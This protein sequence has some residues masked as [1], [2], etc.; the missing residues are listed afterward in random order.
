M[1]PNDFLNGF[2]QDLR[3]AGRQLWKDP[4]SAALIILTLSLGIGANTTVF[5]VVQ[6]VL[7]SPLP[8]DGADRLALIRVDL[9]AAP[10]TPALAPG[11]IT[12]FEEQSRLL[13]GVGFLYGFSVYFSA[14]GQTERL[15]AAVASDDIFRLFRIRP[16]LGRTLGP[17]DKDYGSGTYH[18][19][20]ISHE[21]WQRR[22]GGDPEVIG[23]SVEVEAR[24]R[25]IVGVMPADLRML[26][27]EG[28]GIP[29]KVAVWRPDLNDP[30]K[31]GHH[32]LKPIA[33]LRPGVSF[34]QAQ[35]EIDSIA[36]RFKAR[37]SS[38]YQDG[39][40][41]F[42]ILPLRDDLVAPVRPTLMALLAAAGLLLLICCSNTANLLLARMTGRRQEFSIRAA[43]GASRLRIFRQVLGES[44][45]PAALGGA[46]G[47][48]LAVWAVAALIRL[49]PL[50]LPRLD[51]IR[52]NAQVFGFC[53]AISLLSGT[54]ASLFPAWSL[55]RRNQIQALGRGSRH[56][57]H[58][59]R[60]WVRSSLMASQVALTFL[61]LLASGLLLRSFINL[62]SVEMGFSTEGV[63]TFELS[64]DETEPRERRWLRARSAL[65]RL[66]STAGIEVVGA[67]STGA[68]NQ[69]G[70]P[71]GG[72]G[73]S[74]SS[75][76][77]QK[78]SA[79]SQGNPMADYQVV[80]PGYFE[81]LG[82]RVHSGRA[83]TDQ[84]VEGKRKLAV[85]NQ[86]LAQSFWPA[87]NAVGK[88]L[89][90]DPPS[91]QKS[92]DWYEVVG[93][94]DPVRI[95]GPRQQEGPQIYLPYWT[96]PWQYLSFVVRTDL[97]EQ[98]LAPLL[99]RELGR[100]DGLGPPYNFSSMKVYRE[101]SFA[102]IRL[103]SY[104]F[105][106]LAGMGL[107]LAAFGLFGVISQLAL[108]RNLEMGIRLALG[109]RPAQILKLML[110]QGLVV[111]VAGIAMGAVAGLAA[112]RIL[113]GLLFG[114]T[115]TDLATW[116][117]AG[118]LLAAICL[119][120]CY[121]PARGASQANPLEVLR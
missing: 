66:R 73:A 18:G 45:L 1:Q 35:G 62:R 107:F 119:L 77:L 52:V 97:E 99:R 105:F 31:R 92:P 72:E 71:L 32:Y 95:D 121:F 70:V 83:F 34:E 117:G 98:A 27:G 61:L 9:P 59:I 106:W 14:D 112:T 101:Q 86:H 65:D 48:L 60:G 82:I 81:A 21:L 67:V 110:T 80:L 11:E 44:L 74:R 28:T 29:E 50:G 33:R 46:L 2:V 79:A 120:S 88:R 114:V 47:L 24:P 89:F 118:C 15:P 93:V 36:R 76:A 39:S 38:F 55:G 102:E 75:Y 103:V 84:D 5:S 40:Y 85:I 25:S 3:L 19:V 87:Q 91:D 64:I 56:E 78:P 94:V 96:R 100:L 58:P 23:R 37:H 30:Q 69:S 116:V 115:G 111:A 8:Y 17:Q 4:L 7:L 22:F 109:A 20:M 63:R 43:L 12:D 108:Q 68:A 90:L 49:E 10:G 54:L 26:I 41:R 57:S 113:S 104:L 53:V 42:R 6:G 51:D 13:E 16:A